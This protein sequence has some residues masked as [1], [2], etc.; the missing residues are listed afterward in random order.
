MQE[1]Y[2]R[3]GFYATCITNR[4]DKPCWNSLEEATGKTGIVKHSEDILDVFG[5]IEKRENNDGE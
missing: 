3:Y 4:G 5:S 2:K 1:F